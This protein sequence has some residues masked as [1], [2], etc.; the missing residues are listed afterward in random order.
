MNQMNIYSLFIPIRNH[1]ISLIV[2]KLFLT[3]PWMFP[4]DLI[5]ALFKL[6]DPSNLTPNVNKLAGN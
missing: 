2:H 4:L 1:L 5:I 6:I 3:T